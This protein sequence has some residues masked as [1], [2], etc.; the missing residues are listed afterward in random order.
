V[1]LFYQYFQVKI[2][3]FG[4]PSIMNETSM[5][6]GTVLLDTAVFISGFFKAA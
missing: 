3:G 2:K 1:L 4:N 5:V 6:F